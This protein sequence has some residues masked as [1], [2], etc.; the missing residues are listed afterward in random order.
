MNER[1]TAIAI[2]LAAIVGLTTLFFT[3][4]EKREVDVNTPPSE[5]A[6]NNPYLAAERLLTDLGYD[7]TSKREFA[8]S[9]ELPPEGATAVMA[10]NYASLAQDELDLLLEWVSEG[11]HLVVQIDYDPPRGIDPIFTPMGV[12]A[13]VRAPEN[14]EDEDKGPE[15]NARTASAE[16]AASHPDREAWGAASRDN[17]VTI[18]LGDTTPRRAVYDQYG[19]FAAE[20]SYDAGRVTAVADLRIVRNRRIADNDNAFLLTRML[21]PVRMSGPVWLLIDG[22]FPSL[23]SLLVERIGTVMLAGVGVLLLSLWWA[24]QRFG[25]M[26]PPP[27]S[28]RKSFVEHVEATGR[29][30]W[31]HQKDE[32]LLSDTRAAFLA[33]ARRRHPPLRHSG[34]DTAHADY[35]AQ[36]SGLP[37]EQV[38][39]ALFG[40]MGDRGADFTPRIQILKSL[41]KKL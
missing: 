21:G 38:R 40:P 35:L 32:G 24:A 8:P 12:S 13:Q 19:V 26:I 22:E 28:A 23:W 11:G 15:K 9:I 1:L 10:L 41:W 33:A 5:D 18:D 20:L 6:L 14:F 30:L 36:L 4:Y 3:T 34:A 16:D 31:R 29:F 27:A 2:M 25:P 37:V 17:L 7:V 39:D